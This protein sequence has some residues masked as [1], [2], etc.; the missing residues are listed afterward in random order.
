MMISLARDL[1]IWREAEPAEL[2]PTSRWTAAYVNHDSVRLLLDREH[3]HM[4]YGHN[5]VGKPNGQCEVLVSD[6]SHNQAKIRTSILLDAERERG[7]ERHVRGR[8]PCIVIAE[9]S[10]LA[11]LW[12]RLRRR[13][14]VCS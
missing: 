1:L 12:A 9:H 3:T 2:I 8:A 7:G 14:D 4:S 10:R 5:L 13:I 11:T 6:L